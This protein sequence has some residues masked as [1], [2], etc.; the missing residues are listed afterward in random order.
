MMKMLRFYLSNTDTLR[1]ESLY[2]QIAVA[3]KDFGLKGATV[4]S[5]EMGFGE[6]SRLRSNKF[7][8]LNVKHPVIVEIIDDEQ[9]LLDFLDKV[10]PE[11]DATQKGFLV[12]MQDI[13][14]IYKK[15]G[16]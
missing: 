14:I 16:Q 9:R 15:Q 11:L 13:E 1:H 4:Y 5:G 3:A 6:T 2:E 10:R 7:W 8:E 12:T